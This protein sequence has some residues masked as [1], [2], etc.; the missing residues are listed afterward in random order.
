M[1]SKA[2]RRMVV[3]DDR[4]EDF[5]PPLPPLDPLEAA[6]EEAR[7]AKEGN[8]KLAKAVEI[9]REGLEL[10]VIAEFDHRS[11][12]P[13]DAGTLRKLA[14]AALDRYSAH[15]HQSWRSSKNKLTGATRAGDRSI[16]EE[17]TEE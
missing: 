2:F 14:A 5:K 16:P 10:I 7:H 4:L 15:T 8:L 17:F 9:L 13:V 12:V 1:G 6:Q 11:G 3:N